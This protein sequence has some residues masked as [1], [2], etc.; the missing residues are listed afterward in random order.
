[1]VSVRR[2]SILLLLWV[3]E[4]LADWSQICSD[5]VWRFPKPYFSASCIFLSVLEKRK[6][7]AK[8]FSA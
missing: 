1:M 7:K 2:R 4:D 6:K 3:F 8:T 5:S